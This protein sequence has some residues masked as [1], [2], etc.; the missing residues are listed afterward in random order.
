LTSEN[1]FTS[2]YGS[3]TTCLRPLEN[4]QFCPIPASGLNF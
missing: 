2:V 4:A 1:S 3:I